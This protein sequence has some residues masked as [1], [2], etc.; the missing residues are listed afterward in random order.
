MQAHLGKRLAGCSPAAVTTGRADA[1]GRRA[2][3]PVV[4]GPARTSAR[5]GA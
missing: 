3:R 2:R 4:G 5:E 1:R